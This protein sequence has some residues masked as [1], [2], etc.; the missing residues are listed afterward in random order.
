M[1][2]EK[3]FDLHLKG[4]GLGIWEQTEKEQLLLS[5]T[6]QQPIVH[7]IN[8]MNKK[9]FKQTK[10]VWKCFRFNQKQSFLS[11]FLKLIRQEEGCSTIVGKAY[12]NRTLETLIMEYIAEK[13][14]VG[15]KE[16]LN[17]RNFYSLLTDDS[18]DSAVNRKETFFVFTL[19]P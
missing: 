16:K 9:D 10:K 8:F 12:H 7:G 17:M 18:T 6:G 5:S 3:V 2:H 13:L 1:L 19:N 11:L 14:R 4:F 15:L